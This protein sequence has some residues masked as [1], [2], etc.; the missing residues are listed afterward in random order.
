GRDDAL[1]TYVILLTARDGRD[2]RLAGLE[3]GADDFLTKPFDPGELVARLIIPRPILAMQTQVSAHAAHLVVPHAALS[4][5]TPR[6]APP[7][8]R[9]ERSGHPPPLC[10]GA[11]GRGSVRRPPRRGAVAGAPRRRPV[12]ELQ[13]H[14][15]PPRGRRPAG[16]AGRGAAGRSA[17]ARRGRS[18]R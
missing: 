1:Y 6:R 15:R 7:P 8:A 14:V 9:A 3:A 5:P 18:L 10:R 2:D 11:A 13:R 4:D 17:R 12:Q 16:R